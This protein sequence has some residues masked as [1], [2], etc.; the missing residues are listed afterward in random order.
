MLEVLFGAVLAIASQLVY[1]RF[2]D[3]QRA[4]AVANAIEAELHGAS[5]GDTSFGGFSAHAFEGLFG[6]IAALLPKELARE[7]IG[8]HLRMKFLERT[9][10]ELA[11]HGVPPPVSWIS[12][13]EARRDALAQRLAVFADLH[14]AR[15][16]CSRSEPKRLKRAAKEL[17]G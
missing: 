3:A 16:A 17:E 6:D 2:R 1:E 12:E 9:L 14:A 11:K 7:V 4:K 8:Y 10:P 15:L 5:F 13:M